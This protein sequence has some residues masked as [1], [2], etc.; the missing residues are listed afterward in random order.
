MPRPRCRNGCRR[1]ASP[2]PATVSSRLAGRRMRR[3]S[4]SNARCRPSTWRR[5][6]KVARAGPPSKRQRAACWTDSP[7]NEA[8]HECAH[9][10]RTRSPAAL[11]PDRHRRSA[12]CRQVHALQ[13]PDQSRHRRRELPLLHHRAQCRHRRAARPAAGGPGRDRQARAGAAG[14]GGVCRHRRPG[15]RCQQGRGP[16]QPVPVAHPRDRRHR[17]R[18]AL[19]RGPQRHPRERQGRPD[20][21]HRGH[22]DRALPGRP[23]HRREKPAPLQQGG[24]G[25]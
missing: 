17:Q 23:R 21:R 6:A 14:R 11:R 8:T 25:R 15:G 5:S 13:R 20:L 18:G 22:P 3:L 10:H 7:P 24:A 1:A 4:K 16:G 19:L 2:F 12:Q 9:H